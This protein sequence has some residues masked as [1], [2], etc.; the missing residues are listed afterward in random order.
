MAVVMALMGYY[1]NISLEGL[2]KSMKNL[3]QDSHVQTWN[4]PNMNEVS[5]L[6]T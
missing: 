4:V 2:W 6:T 3:S 5:M 1:R